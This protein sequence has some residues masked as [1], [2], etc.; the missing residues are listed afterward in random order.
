MAEVLIP[1]L[2]SPQAAYPLIQHQLLSHILILLRTSQSY[3]FVLFIA[4]MSLQYRKD[5]T[6]NSWHKS[7]RKPAIPNVHVDIDTPKSRVHVYD[8]DIFFT[9]PDRLESSIASKGLERKSPLDM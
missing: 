2:I 8:G 5:G 7:H 4:I 9:W 3:A 1:S 6:S